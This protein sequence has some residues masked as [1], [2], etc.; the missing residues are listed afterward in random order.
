MDY[1][2]LLF[3]FYAM[4]TGKLVLFENSVNEHYPSF[5]QSKLIR[6]KNI[7]IQTKKTL[8]TGLEDLNNVITYK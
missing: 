8:L 2:A 6:I 5:V 3:C 4:N 7:G 1:F